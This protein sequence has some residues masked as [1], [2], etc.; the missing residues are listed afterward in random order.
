MPRPGLPL[1]MSL[2][3]RFSTGLW[4][5]L[6]ARPPGLES[7]IGLSEVRQDRLPNKGRTFSKRKA[8]GKSPVMTGHTFPLACGRSAYGGSLLGGLLGALVLRS[9]AAALDVSVV[10]RTPGRGCVNGG[11]A[12]FVIQRNRRKARSL[13][14]GL[15][16]KAVPI[17]VSA[18]A[19][20]TMAIPTPM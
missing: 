18:T 5:C 4:H 6:F 10:L 17:T 13:S 20:S 11:S 15:P 1:I 9:Q 7:L 16:N 2:I 8:R 19:S 12:R 14:S 3:V